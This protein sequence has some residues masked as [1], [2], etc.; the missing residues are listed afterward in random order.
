LL[1]SAVALTLTGA[2]ICVVFLVPALGVWRRGAVDL[3]RWLPGLP[4]YYL[5]VSLAA[6]LALIEYCNRPFVWN[7]TE[8]GRARSSR[9]RKPPA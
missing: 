7:K 4:L 6:W 5:L 8:H 2:G 3:W 1:L 9:Y